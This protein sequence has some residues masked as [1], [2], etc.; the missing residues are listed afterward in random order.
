MPMASNDVSA[1]AIYARI[2]QDDGTALGVTRQVEDCRKLAAELGWKVAEEYIDNDVSAYSAKRRPAYAAMLADIADGSRDA[3]I[4]YH[5]DRLT[6]RPIELEQF[7]AVLSA[8]GVSQVKF[9]AGTG[10]DVGTGDGLLVLRMLSAVA[11]NESASK[12]RRVRRKMEELAAAGAPMM[13]GGRPF[14]YNNDRV[15]VKPDEA[16]IVAE[17]AERF[18]AG[19]S[20]FS[21]TRWLNDEGVPTA[22]SA[23]EWRT[24]SVRQILYSARISGQREHRGE[25]VGPGQWP[26]II[27][28]EQS[29][30][31]RAILDDPARRTNRTA[32]SYLLSGMLRCLECGATLV[33]H[34]AKNR[35]SYVCRTEPGL[36]GCGGIRIDADRVEE[37][38]T[39]AVLYRLDTPELAAA[40]SGAQAAGEAG[41]ALS[42]QITSDEAQLEELAE[43]Y[44]AKSITA[45]EWMAARNPIEERL[46]T[47]R[48]QIA[49]ATNTTDLARYIGQGEQLRTQWAELNLDRQRAVVRTVIDH[50]GVKRSGKNRFDPSRVVPQWRL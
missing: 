45:K 43:L 48:R 35:R 28:P 50:A 46:R 3:V 5:A 23:S 37:L 42:G 9:V 21:L 10:I 19:E 24:T 31:I 7:L 38:I 17:L 27:K 12:S 47:T 13:G 15:T 41:E 34:P 18:L 6:R 14:G 44:A 29:G 49:R 33:S 36:G 26:A 16:V 30:R 2:S 25:I 4:V 40:L 8:A 20:L 22:G 1:A 11:A 32:R 39:E